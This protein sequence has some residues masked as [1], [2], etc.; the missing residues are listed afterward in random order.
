MDSVE[1]KATL[2]Q[3]TDLLRFT[4]GLFI[5]SNGFAMIC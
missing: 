5:R 4:P 1:I 2:Q 3:R